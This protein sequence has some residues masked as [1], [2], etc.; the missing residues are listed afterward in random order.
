MR[1]FPTLL[2]ALAACG[3]GDKTIPPRAEPD[4]EVSRDLVGFGEVPLGETE[5]VFLSVK[6]N[7]G[8]EVEL[9]YALDGPAVFSVPSP[10][11]PAPI[12]PEDSITLTVQYAPTE[13]GEFAGT[14]QVSTA[15]DAVA[16]S[17]I[18]LA[19][20]PALE[21]TPGA[22]DLELTAGDP[23]GA[24]GGAPFTLRN[25]GDGD[26]VVSGVVVTAGDP[27]FTL[28]TPFEPLVLAPAT[29]ADVR[30]AWDV[31]VD[32]PG[33]IDGELRIDSN[34]PTTPVLL[35]PLVAVIGEATTTVLDTGDT[36]DTGDTFHPTDSATDTGVVDTGAV[37]TGDT[38]P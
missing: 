9:S 14:L 7:T 11:L 30:V 16:V 17:L 34:D 36:S 10:D 25:N 20:A 31:P 22:L 8:R 28:A 5:V 21:V 4:L 27:Q 29:A 33:R 19:R 38:G 1:L 13:A 24:T 23:E 35:L 2:L 12:P 15:A 26:L 18:G 3:D 32:T 37:H 6:N